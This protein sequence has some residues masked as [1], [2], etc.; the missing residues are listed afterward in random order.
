[1]DSAVFSSGGREFQRAFVIERGYFG[2][3]K[4]LFADRCLCRELAL[5]ERMKLE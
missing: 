2:G 5:V 3:F 1:M 4:D